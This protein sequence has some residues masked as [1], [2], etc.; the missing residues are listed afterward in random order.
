MITIVTAFYNIN[1]DNWTN[2][3]RSTE[4]YFRC[5]KL[6][7]Q[8]ENEIIIFTQ[9]VYEKEFNEIKLNIKNNLT[10]YYDDDI[11]NDDTNFQR[12][13]E[14][15]NNSEYLKGIKNPDCPEYWNTSYV[16]V[17]FLKSQFCINAIEKN[18]NISDMVAWIDFG[19]VK[20]QSQIPKSKIWDYDFEDKIHLWCIQNIPKSINLKRII[21]SNSVFIQG[22]HIVAPKQK[23]IMINKF[24]NEQMEYLLNNNLIDDD[25]TMLLMSYLNNPLE[26]K[27][28]R[29]YINS[30]DLDWFF[31]FQYFNIYCDEDRK[32]EMRKRLR[33]RNN[34]I[35]N[36]IR[37]KNLII[38]IIYKIINMLNRKVFK[39]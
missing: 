33:E 3:S 9:S 36:I 21:K 1:R 24:M 39:H 28:H 32:H 34:L 13:N 12:I 5:F 25:Q 6:L 16:L 31:I 29:E 8:L 30:K 37:N 18:E 27:I 14:I 11:I 7:C 15:Q 17:N 19:Y 38:N 10:V 4:E 20:K 26:F 2:Y 35:P 23:W 22:G